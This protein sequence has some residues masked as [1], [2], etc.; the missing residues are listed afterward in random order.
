MGVTKTTIG[1]K[2]KHYNMTKNNTLY[3]N[4]MVGVTTTWLVGTTIMWLV[5][6]VVTW[7]FVLI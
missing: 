5:V 2:N 6:G 1:G 7:L 4:G 3:R